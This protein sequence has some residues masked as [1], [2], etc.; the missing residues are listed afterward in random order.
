MSQAC[1]LRD[2]GVI[3]LCVR[4]PKWYALV[5]KLSPLQEEEI[6]LV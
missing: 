4:S 1:L 3:F 2:D 6:F 5:L